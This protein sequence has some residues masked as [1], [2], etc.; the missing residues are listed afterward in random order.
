MR[1]CT[2]C[3]CARPPSRLRA[4]LPKVLLHEHLDG[5]LRPPTLLELCRAARPG[6]A[7][8]PTPPRWPPGSQANAHAGSL[9]R[10]LDGFALTVAAMAT[11]AALERVAFEAAEDARADGCVLAEFRIAPL[12]FEPTACRGEAAVEALLAGLRAQRRCRCGLI[13]CAMR[14]EPPERHAARRAAGAALRRAAA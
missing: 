12:L 6:R 1:R 3:H 13:V 9:G 5:G 11:P 8:R 14:H 10:Y 4:P 2:P 7:G